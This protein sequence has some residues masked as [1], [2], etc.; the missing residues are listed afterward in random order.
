MSESQEYK[1][2]LWQNGMM[3]AMVRSANEDR[4]IAEINHYA[5]MYGQ[6]GPCE[7]R[8]KTRSPTRK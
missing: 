8:N 7:I 4:A 2:E 3:V 6:D 1:F 5:M